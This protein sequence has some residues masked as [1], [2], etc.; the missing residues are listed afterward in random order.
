MLRYPKI[1]LGALV[2]VFDVKF[3]G[4]DLHWMVHVQGN[5]PV[6]E[7]VKT[8]RPDIPIIFG[9]IS[10]TYYAEQLIQYPFIDLVMRGYDTHEPTAS[11][12]EAIKQGR[13]LSAIPNLLWKSTDGQVHDN[14]F[15]YMPDAFGCGIDWS[16]QPQEA[17]T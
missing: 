12:L 15:S 4:I 1:N 16:S 14:G 5:T 2:E 6:A 9:G 17:A 8:F 11:Q 13:D 10:S 3:L 7:R